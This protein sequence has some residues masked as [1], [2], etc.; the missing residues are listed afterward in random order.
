MPRAVAG[1]SVIL[2]DLVLAFSGVCSRPSANRILTHAKFA[3]T[4]GFASCPARVARLAR[5]S[6]RR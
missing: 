1:R 3:A 2:R 5:T 4:L 6:P